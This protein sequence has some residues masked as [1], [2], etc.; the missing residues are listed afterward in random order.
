MAS[1]N[2]SPMPYAVCLMPY[3]LCLNALQ[4][5]LRWRRAIDRLGRAL[6]KY[7]D[8]LMQAACRQLSTR[9]TLPEIE[10]GTLPE[11]EGGP[12][13]HTESER[14]RQRRESTYTREDEQGGLGELRC[15]S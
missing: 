6:P 12:H 8:L 9:H 15:V 4:E 14:Q 5:S 13:L 11:I 7:Q 3:A 1:R 10:G 2:R